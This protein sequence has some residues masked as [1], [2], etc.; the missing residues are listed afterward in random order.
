VARG[1]SG[2]TTSDTFSRALCSDYGVRSARV[3]ANERAELEAELRRRTDAGDHSGAMTAAVRGYGY[4]LMGF[5]VGLTGNPGEADEIFA[6]ACEKLWRA[7]PSFRW[8]SSFRVWAYVVARNEFYRA[9]RSPA[10]KRRVT[11]DD[12]PE[13][14]AAVEH[15]RTTT[16]EY[17]R[18]EV[19]DAFARIRESLEPDER[20]LLGL[21]V[22]RELEWVDIARVLG[23]E[24]ADV[25]REAA[26][27]RKRFERLKVRLRELARAQGIVG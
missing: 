24:D 15:V 2:S 8:D 12:A 23:A 18:T 9:R 13:V 26:T 14:A 11:L 1:L 4:E 3:D 21:R 25:K 22:D 10:A 16:A 20:I 6:T 5:L 27:L 7:L 19:K 17:R